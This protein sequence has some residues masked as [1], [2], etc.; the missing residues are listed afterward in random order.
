MLDQKLI[1]VADFRK[2][3]A[4]PLPQPQDVHLPG[5]QGQAPYFANYVREQLL[6]TYPAR[7]VYG[8][9]CA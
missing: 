8:G 1:G 9:G 5:T 3:D 4:T 7:T 6:Q 2:A